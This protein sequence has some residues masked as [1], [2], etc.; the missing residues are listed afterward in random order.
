MYRFLIFS[1]LLLCSFSGYGQS[2]P[3]YKNKVDTSITNKTGA[4]SITAVA[5]GSRFKELA[6][7]LDS[8]SGSLITEISNVEAGAVDSALFVTLTRLRDSLN[9]YVKKS[10]SGS[11]YLTPYGASIVYVPLARTLSIN[12][13]SYDLSQNRSWTIAG[14][15]DSTTAGYGLLEIA[16]AILADTSL[17]RTVANSYT[18]A[19]VDALISAITESD[20]IFT[21]NKAHYD[22]AYARRIT[23]IQITGTTTK[24]VTVTLGSGQTLTAT[25]T[26]NNN[27][28]TPGW[29][30]TL[31]GSQFNVD[32]NSLYAIFYKKAQ[33]DSI[34]NTIDGSETYVEAGS[35]ATV[36]GTGTSGDPY[37]ISCNCTPTV[38]IDSTTAS[39]GLIET[40]NALKVDTSLIRTVANSYNKLEVVNLI[41]A[42]NHPDSTFEG[43][44][45]NEVNNRIDVD[46]STLDARY[47]KFAYVD[48]AVGSVSSGAYVFGW[49]LINNLGTVYVDTGAGKVATAYDVSLKVNKADSNINGGY[50]SYYHAAQTYQPIGVYLTGADTTHFQHHNDTTTWDATRFW[51]QSQNYLTSFT[52]VDPLSAHTSDSLSVW[53]TV[54][55]LIDSIDAIVTPGLPEVLLQNNSAPTYSIGIRNVRFSNTFNSYTP[56]LRWIHPLDGY[57]LDLPNGFGY[58]TADTIQTTLTKKIYSNPVTSNVPTSPSPTYVYVKESGNDTMKLATFPTGGTGDVVGPS[59]ATDNAIAR[60]DGTTGK[61]IQN[62]TVTVSDAGVVAGAS[63]A[64][65]QLTGAYTSAGMTMNTA[66]LLGRTTAS[67]GSVEEI[68]VNSP[69]TFSS[70]SLGIQ[71]A[72]AD[73]ITKGAATFSPRYFE[74]NG[75]IVNRK[76]ATQTLTD[77]ATITWN[78]NSGLNAVVTLGGNRTLSITNLRDGDYFTLI[79]K[80]DGTGSRTLTLPASTKVI[81]GGA[82]AV[83]LTTTA[84][85]QDI[86]TFY[87]SGTTLYCNYGKNYN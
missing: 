58:L 55:Q 29:A 51:V 45:I 74:V 15:A 18:K 67:I 43:W 32:S 35:N 34:F 52:E 86:L 14:T 36:T 41:S 85:A 27:T 16:N 65:S 9:K 37:V 31:V 10:D 63:I 59:S 22:T 13:V 82:G 79:V 62:S 57:V 68:G 47:T 46:S 54:S 83:T 69:L 20:P 44:A 70:T 23:N 53:V 28:Y 71:N 3:N 8:I 76:T 66:R 50:E 7:I 77:G 40:N 80:Q 25:F 1:L 81:A 72:A 39:Y 19:Q 11:L 73:S 6:D 2:I 17:L 21:P 61:L 12:G 48:S 38:S 42:A 75:G 64:G 5:V 60:F 78:L 4:K 24:T 84:S 26:D 33:V 87:Y 49:G 56:T 30:M